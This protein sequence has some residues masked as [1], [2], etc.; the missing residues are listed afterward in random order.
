MKVPTPKQP[1]MTRANRTRM[2]EQLLNHTLPTSESVQAD[3]TRKTEQLAALIVAERAILDLDNALEVATRTLRAC[4]FQ[5]ASDRLQACK[6]GVVGETLRSLTENIAQ[7]EKD[8]GL[9]QD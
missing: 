5:N 2:L 7:A 9:W 1:I 4:Q 8:L 6:A 3:T